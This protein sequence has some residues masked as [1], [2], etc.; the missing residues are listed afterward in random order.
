[1]QSFLRHL[2]WYEHRGLRVEYILI[3]FLAGSASVQALY[4]LSNKAPPI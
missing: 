3:V 2:K 4:L 1:M